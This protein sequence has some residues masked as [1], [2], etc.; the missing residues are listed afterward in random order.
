MKNVIYLNKVAGAIHSE[1]FWLK[2]NATLERI[3]QRYHLIADKKK[4]RVA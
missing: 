2:H 1:G 3:M 4:G